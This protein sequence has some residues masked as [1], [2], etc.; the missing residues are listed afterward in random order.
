MWTRYKAKPLQTEQNISLKSHHTFGIAVNAKYFA[1]CS[2]ASAVPEMFSFAAEKNIPHLVLGGG[3][4]V[5][6]TKDFN[7]LVIKSEIKGKE[8]VREDEEYVWLKAGAGENWHQL[9]MYCVA[10]G[11]GGIENLSL[12]PGCAGAAPIQNIGAYG[13]ELKES[14]YELEAWHLYDKCK[15][16]FNH[17]DCRFGY[18]DSVFK[19]EYKNKLVITSV[20]LRLN[21]H[22]KINTSYQA[23]ALELEKAGIS[24]PGISD[25]AA[26]V[27]R[28]RS[29]KLPDPAVIGNAGSFFKNPSITAVQFEA[30]KE[31]FPVIVGYL[32]PDGSYKLAA[33]WLIEHSGPE[34]TTGAATWKGF[35][36]GDAGCHEKQALVL[37]N[38]GQAT[39]QEIWQLSED[40]L[41]SVHNKFGV[42]LEREVN[43]L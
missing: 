10:Q 34:N 33:G 8:Q 26:A 14:F 1:V 4:N 32:L 5:L 20:T 29:S 35:R 16:Q 22:P 36:R 27:I 15:V 37:V 2:E 17:N 39:G 12:I 40:I 24:S 11:W 23:L 28:I 38:H 25:V 3:S 42:R 7:G 41:Q 6:F 18:R 19:N 13:V 21:K 30:L 31:Q 9:V 43:I